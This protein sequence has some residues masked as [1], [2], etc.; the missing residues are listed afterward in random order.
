MTTSR[1]EFRRSIA[2]IVAPFSVRVIGQPY[3]PK[4]LARIPN[5]WSSTRN[6]DQRCRS[7][8]CGRPIPCKATAGTAKRLSVRTSLEE[9]FAGSVITTLEGLP[10]GVELLPASEATPDDSP[11]SDQGEKRQF[12]PQTSTTTLVLMTGHDSPITT[13]PQFVRAVVTPVYPDGSLGMPL[14][15]QPIPLM[16]T[17]PNPEELRTASLSSR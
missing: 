1:R 11:P 3:R 13:V 16:V 4:C 7:T 2:L 12:L 8:R 10:P 9:G 6:L 14:S 5:D 15:V 17:Q